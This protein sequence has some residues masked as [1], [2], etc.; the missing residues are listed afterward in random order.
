MDL[1]DLHLYDGRSSRS[2]RGERAEK[3]KEKKN[4][5]HPSRREKREEGGRAN[6]PLKWVPKWNV[7]AQRLTKGPPNPP[8]PN[9]GGGHLSLDSHSLEFFPVFFRRASWLWKKL[10]PPPSL[11]VLWEMITLRVLFFFPS[12][13]GPMI[14][15]SQGKRSK[16]LICSR[17]Y[18]FSPRYRKTN[19]NKYK[20]SDISYFLYTRPK[21]ISPLSRAERERA[22]AQCQSLNQKKRSASGDFWQVRANMSAYLFMCVISSLAF[23]SLRCCF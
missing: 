19:P 12:D 21:I 2:S 6:L 15:T 14:T 1:D 16:P 9:G 23:L 10:F 7:P 3:E 22:E 18:L 11:S 5:H 4:G 8:L 13:S 20:R 17:V